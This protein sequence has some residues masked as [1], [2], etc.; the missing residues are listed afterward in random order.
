MFVYFLD[1]AKSDLI[2]QPEVKIPT[3]CMDRALLMLE[4][5]QYIIVLKQ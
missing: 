3:Q 5:V 4:I 1:Q 2:H